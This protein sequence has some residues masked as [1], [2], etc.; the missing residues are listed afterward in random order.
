MGEAASIF[1]AS[2]D[3]CGSAADTAHVEAKQNKN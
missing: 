3:P 1:S 2:N